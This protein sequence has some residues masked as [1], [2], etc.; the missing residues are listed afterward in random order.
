MNMINKTIL[1]VG[2]TGAGKSTLINALVNYVMG[3]KWE[4]DIWFQIVE[5]REG[6]EETRQSESQT[7][8]VIVYQIFG[9]EGRTVPFSLTV[10]DTPGFGDTRG[11]ERDAKISERLLQWFRSDFGV[12]EINAVGLVLKA[13]DNRL[14]DRLRYVFD[15]AISLFGKNMKNNLVALITHSDG[16]PPNDTL[17]ALQDAKIKI[18]NNSDGVPNHF[19]FNNRQTTERTQSMRPLKYAW[20]LT[21]EQIEQ[22][23][24]F[25]MNMIPQK[26]NTT[27]SVL[28]ERIK[29]NECIRN[30]QQRVEFIELQENMIRQEQELQKKYEEKKNENENYIEEV[31]EPYKEKQNIKGGGWG[32]LWLTYTGAI[33]C[34]KCEET[35][36]VGC[37]FWFSF[38][39]LY[40]VVFEGDNCTACTNKCGRKDH[41]KDTWIYVNK[42]R[43][44]RRTREDMKKKYESNKE[45]FNSKCSI[46]ENMTKA[47]NEKQEAKHQLLEECYQHVLTLEEIAL[48][49]NALSLLKHLDYLVEK[50]TDP[51]YEEELQK[52]QAIRSRIGQ[53]KGVMTI[54]SAHDQ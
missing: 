12:H 11:D 6:G 25:L 49:V 24:D 45:K 23:A 42:T 21:E 14:S 52:L 19:V 31:D 44:V 35:C 2:E 34:E 40:S 36:H 3:V 22:F 32:F 30:L 7:S 13:S 48:N 46:L 4:D 53:D 39:G 17:K 15:S 27:V 29:L 54:P 28:D 5:D 37:E 9:F 33:S 16:E 47:L 1:L 50:M 8:D 43:K 20:E 38:K 51:R 26:L 10:I 18:P 41:V